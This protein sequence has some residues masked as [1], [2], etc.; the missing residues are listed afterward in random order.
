MTPPG[1][2]LLGCPRHKEKNTQNMEVIGIVVSKKKIFFT[3]YPNVI[4]QW[5]LSVGA[6]RVLN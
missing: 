6:T 3:F 4:S 2:G 1:R 5:G